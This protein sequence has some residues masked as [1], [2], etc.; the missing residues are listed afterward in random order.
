MSKTTGVSATPARTVSCDAVLLDANLLLYAVDRRSPQNG[1]T[2]EWIEEQLGGSRRVGLPWQTLAT[3]LRVATHT[4][5]LSNPLSSA[6]AWQ[7]VA[8]WLAAPAAWIPVPGPEHSRILGELI[9][10]FD[11]GG[12]LVPDAMLAALAI[13]HGLVVCSADTDFARFEPASVRWQNPL[14]G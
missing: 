2:V 10:K 8:D 1:Q 11:I 7:Q 5:I 12:N 6:V 14:T 4:R 3:F 13:E 9:L